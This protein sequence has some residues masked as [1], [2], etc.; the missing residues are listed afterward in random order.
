MKNFK[1][2]L[3]LL[4]SA[5]FALPYLAL[6]QKTVTTDIN[7]DPIGPTSFEA[8]ATSILDALSSLIAGVA[9]IMLV[10]AG[11]VY[12]FSQGEEQRVTLAKKIATGAVIGLAVTVGAKTIL[13]EIYKVISPMIT[14]SSDV[15]LA[16]SA[17]EVVTNILNLLLSVLA[18]IG[19]ISLVWGGILYLT[20]GG[21]QDRAEK[22]KKQLIYSII[23]LVIAIGSLVIIK[24]I[25]AV[26]GG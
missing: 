14:P 22:G 4:I 19:V 25:Q 2:K 21:N 17:F 7:I 6:A 11:I 16:P 18:M 10:I 24:Q 12:I 26:L 5:I 15:S 9:M 23:G 20:S 3:Y 13:Q 8:L 1:L